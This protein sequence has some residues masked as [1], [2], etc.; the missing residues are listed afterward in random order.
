MDV[1]SISHSGHAHE[2][3]A[4]PANQQQQPPPPPPPEGDSVELTEKAKA[5]A[6]SSVL[7][8]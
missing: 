3:Q 7:D 2:V 1:S 6:S 5:L 8:E 4:K